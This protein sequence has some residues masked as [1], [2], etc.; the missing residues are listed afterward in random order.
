MAPGNYN[1]Y[2]V[3]IRRNTLTPVFCRILQLAAAQ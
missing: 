1:N 2:T 3:T